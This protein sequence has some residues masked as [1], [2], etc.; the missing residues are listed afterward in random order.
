MF[1]HSLYSSSAGNACRVYN[2]ETSI[3]ID[4]GVSYKKLAK[5][6]GEGFAPDA[7][8]ITHEHGDHIA[9]AGVLGRKTGCPIYLPQASYMEKQATF[10]KCSTHYIEGGSV[11]TIG[12]FEVL[13]FSTRHDSHASVGYVVT[14]ISTSK[15]FG[16]LTDTGSFSKLMKKSLHG[17]DAYLLEADYDLQELEDYEDYAD[18]HKERIR[19][20]WGHL[21]NDQTLDFIDECI[22]LENTQWILLGHLSPRTNSPALLLGQV[23]ERFVHAIHKFKIA[24]TEEPL[25]IN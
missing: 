8:F 10:E 23:Q 11:T 3:L 17:C 13:A 9:G 1:V 4:A 22:D 25:E 5:I 18:V 21:G 19:G 15:Q 7:L 14:E 12:D 16:Y 24:P 20:P 6:A 2:D